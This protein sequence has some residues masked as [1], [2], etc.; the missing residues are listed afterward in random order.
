MRSQVQVLAGP[1]AIVAG[2]SAVGS[3]PG[4]PT[5]SLGRAGA[6]RPSRRPAPWPLPGPSTGA[7]GSTT[8]THRGH[9]SNQAGSH[10]AGAATSRCSLLPPTA[11]AAAA[12]A[13]PADPAWSLSGQAPPPAPYPAQVRHRHPTDQQATWAAPPASR[14]AR[15][16]TEPLHSAAA[17]RDSTRSRGDGCPPHRPGPNATARHGRRRTRPNPRGG[18]Q[19][20]G[21]WT[22]G[23]LRAGPRTGGQQTTGPPDPQ[24]TNPGERTPDGLDTGRLDRR[25]LH[26]D[27]GWVDTRCWTPTGDRCH[28]WRP[29]SVDQGD[30]A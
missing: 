8:T 22:G 15:P 23:P 14:P 3:G 21:R 12:G 13:P 28:G 1:P 18:R 10:A 7:S 24:T 30:D 17:H 26:D 5:A 27:T 16:S 2:H 11:P 6:A 19:P 20:A 29:G 4:T 25:I 9:T